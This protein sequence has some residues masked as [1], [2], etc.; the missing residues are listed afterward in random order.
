MIPGDPVLCFCD[1]I[2]PGEGSASN[3]HSL[4]EE[5]TVLE[6]RVRLSFFLP[7]SGSQSP[8]LAKCSCVSQSDATA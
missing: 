6:P 7:P 5:A 1:W 8:S 3:L 4:F 2:T